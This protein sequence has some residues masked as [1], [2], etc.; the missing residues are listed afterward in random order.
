MK[1]SCPACGFLNAGDAAFCGRCGWALHRFCSD[2]GAG[3]QAAGIS[4][5]TSCGAELEQFGV[6]VERKIVSV[7][8]VD[9]VGFTGLAENLDPEDVRALL[10]PYY[11]RVRAEL[12]RYGGTVEKFIGDAVMALFGAPAAHEDDPERAVRAAN[13]VREAVVGLGRAPL[14]QELHVRIGVATGEAV[15]NVGARPAEGEPMAHGD[16]VNTAARLQVGAPVDGILVDER[17]YRGTR[18]QVDFRPASP[19]VAKGKSK[20]MAVWELVAPRGRRGTDRF[21]HETELVGRADELATLIGALDH[22]RRG[23]SAKLV[24]LVGPPGIG[25]SRLVWELFR[26]VEQAPELVYWR[27]GRSLPYGDGVTFWALADIVK[28][29]AGILAT[30]SAPS[31]EE[32]LRLAIDDVLP[33][34]SEARWVEEHLAPLAGLALPGDSYADHRTEAFAAW[35]RFF[36]AVA[37]RRP[38]VLVFEDVHWADEGL[39]EFVSDHLGD[40]FAGGLLIVATCRPELIEHRSDW[41][42]GRD[43]ETLALK[44]LSDDE[45]SRLVI[46]KLEATV[47]PDP[48]LAALLS[49]SGGNPLY[50]EE[51]VRMLLDQNMLEMVGPNWELTTPDLPLPDSIQ[52]IVAARLDALP[53]AEKALIQDAAVVGKGFWLGALAALEG[54]QRLSAEGRLDELERKELIRRESESVVQS[55]PQYSF[56]HIIV[57]DVAYGQIPRSSRAEKHRRAAKW[58]ESLAPDRTEDRAEMLAHHYLNALQY[59]RATGEAADALVKRTATALREVGDRSLSLHTF[60]KAAHFYAEA[61]TLTPTDGPERAELLFHLGT[62]RFHAESGGADDLEE[63][64]DAFLAQGQLERAAEAMV[65][66]GELLWMRADPTAFACLEEAVAL[67]QSS[68]PSPAKAHVLSSRA[69]FLMIADENDEAIRVG[70]EALD[71]ASDLCLEEVRAHALDSIGLARARLGDAQGIADLEASIAIAVGIN[72]LESVRG[73]A[74][75]GNTLVEAGELARAFRIYEEGRSAA[76]R[77][78]DADRISWFDAERMYEWYWRGRWDELLELAD[79]VIARIQPGLTVAIEVDARLLRS[80]IRVGLDQRSA[81][82]ED[83]SRA[84]ELG[85]RAGYPEMLVPALA[86]HART[87]EASGQPD[88]AVACTEELLSLWPERCPSSYWLADLAFVHHWLDRSDRLLQAIEQAKTKTRWLDAAAAVCERRLEEAAELLAEIGSTPDAALARLL[89]GELLLEAGNRQEAE[90]Q[91][92]RALAEL[93]ALGA[94]YYIRAGEELLLPA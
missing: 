94:S 29:H 60:A 80:R 53:R 40:R 16:V 57:R 47:L 93:R 87:L 72:S 69:R 78:G 46:G 71:M 5:C 41:G 77:L 73:Y 10:D 42:Q 39:L 14:S 32:K 75:L 67:L 18:L 6:S 12:E 31:A 81:A 1:V 13:A 84:V 86:L 61:L 8:F 51:Y 64:R 28:A 68:P 76:K 24:T 43:A 38:L 70:L 23:T 82:L 49:R 55:E 89:A 22:V 74:N 15:V 21:R 4:Y 59:T 79:E 90:V 2:C 35:R 30:D 54:E 91:L 48:L 63:A 88:A 58:I 19:L 26:H 45:T 65:M 37:A 20:P 66:I 34:K 50:V 25:K 52:A 92:E 11:A 85:H 33:D 36:E 7:L 44:P 56:R 62:A 83:S 27:Q 9:L 3:P 17:T